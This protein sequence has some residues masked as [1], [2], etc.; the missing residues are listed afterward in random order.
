MDMTEYSRIAI[1]LQ[2]SLARPVEE[3]FRCPTCKRV[4]STLEASRSLSPA[5]R[6]G[7]T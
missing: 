4:Y 5:T 2:D 1:L 6:Y 3:E 7:L